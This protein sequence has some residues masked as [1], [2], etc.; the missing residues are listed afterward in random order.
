MGK[1]FDRFLQFL[2]DFVRPTT[3]R[4]CFKFDVILFRR[5]GVIAEKPRVGH[6][7]RNLPCTV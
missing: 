3:L 4:K 5:Y 6:L 1:P 2:W 7:A